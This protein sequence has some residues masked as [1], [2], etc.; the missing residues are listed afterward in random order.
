MIKKTRHLS[1][2][3][4]VVGTSIFRPDFRDYMNVSSSFI[5]YSLNIHSD[6]IF[7]IYAPTSSRLDSALLVYIYNQDKSS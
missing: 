1:Y 2:I 5:Y 3:M 7:H 6:R 4:N